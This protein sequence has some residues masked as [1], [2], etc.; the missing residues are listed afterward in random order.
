MSKAP[1]AEYSGDHADSGMNLSWFEQLDDEVLQESR[2]TEPDAE[3]IL[4]DSKKMQSCVDRRGDIRIKMDRLRDLLL[5]NISAIMNDT[6]PIQNLATELV[7]DLGDLLPETSASALID[8]VHL[9][10]KREKFHRVEDRRHRRDARCGKLSELGFNIGQLRNT[11]KAFEGIVESKKSAKRELEAADREV[12]A[13]RKHLA[14][15]EERAALARA[16][17]QHISS[18][19]SQY[20]SYGEA[21]FK[22]C[23]ELRSAV[24]TVEGN[25]ETDEAFVHRVEATIARALAVVVGVDG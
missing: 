13:A 8:V 17:F 16:K 21:L 12:A 24:L 9:A 20:R 5:R 10:E 1:E 25:P 7:S 11:K 4:T 14:E 22:K 19:Q 3:T 2:T 23:E 6:Q 18:A 15:T